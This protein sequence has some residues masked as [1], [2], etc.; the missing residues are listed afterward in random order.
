MSFGRNSLTVKADLTALD[1]MLGTIATDI[2]EAMRPAAQAAAQV[3]YDE[4][5]KNVRQIGKK[6]GNLE[7]SIY[8]VY[9]KTESTPKKAVYHISWNARTAPHGGLVEY[10][11]IQRYMA[12]VNPK[13]EW[14]TAIRPDKLG[15]PKPKRRASQAI[16]DAYYMPRPGGPQFVAAKPYIRP[17]LDKTPMAVAAAESVIYKIMMG[18]V[19]YER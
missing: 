10:G 13:G 5:K 2:D 8:Q 16:K 15:T 3:F 19:G 18:G 7:R 12:Y 11:H 4:V 1:Q 14:K 6:T 9:S 17:A